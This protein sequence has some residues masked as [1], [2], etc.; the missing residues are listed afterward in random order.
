ME[1]GEEIINRIFE[2]SRCELSVIIHVNLS[3]GR[4]AQLLLWFSFVPVGPVLAQ[5]IVCKAVAEELSAWWSQEW[6]RKGWDS[7]SL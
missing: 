2:A 5:C 3:E 7:L 1:D 6:K 4:C